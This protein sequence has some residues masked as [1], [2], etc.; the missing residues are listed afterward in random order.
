M[1]IEHFI[2]LCIID[3]NF[4]SVHCKYVKQKKNIFDIIQKLQKQ[5]KKDT[6]LIAL[7]I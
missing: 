6:Y 5:I 2:S 7:W 4:P 1:T 3:F